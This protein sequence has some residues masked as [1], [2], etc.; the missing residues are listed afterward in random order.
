MELYVHIPFCIRKCQYCDFLSAPS[1][2]STREAYVQALLREIRSYAGKVSSGVTSV[3]IGGGTPSVLEPEWI[4]EIMEAIE[5]TFW[6]TEDAEITMEAN[7][8]TVTEAGLRS[9]RTCGINR[10]SLG[11]QSTDQEELKILGRIHTYS[12]FLESYQAARRAGFDNINVDLMFAVPGQT[13]EQWI[14]TLKTVADLNPAHISAYSLIIEEG[15]PFGD[16]EPEDLPDEDTEY[17]MYDDTMEVLE[18]YGYHKYEISN[19]AREGYEC[20]HNV[21]YWRRTEYLGLGL[22]AAS[23]YRGQRFSVTSDM[24]EYLRDSDLP[25]KIHRDVETLTRA[26]QMEEFMFL[27]LRMMEGV[28]ETEFQRQFGCAM[29]SIYGSILE[30][31][32]NEGFLQ[33]RQEFW[34]LTE[35]GI[36]VSNYILADFLLDQ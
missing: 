9:Y 22:G 36:H 31:Y 25:E 7:P 2:K 19:Y 29:D 30:K 20:R 15:T 24:E 11:L 34:S 8:G 35:K 18:R 1:D 27:G 28:S 17:R 23:L 3:F 26:D 16:K 14:H 12:D 13:R 21:G 4:S 33:K 32:R 6:L 10:L 5:E